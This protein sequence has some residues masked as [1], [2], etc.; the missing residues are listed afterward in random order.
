MRRLVGGLV[1]LA[2]CAALM[3]P[4]AGAAKGTGLTFIFYRVESLWGSVRVDFHG[5]PAAGCERQG[6]CGFSGS[7]VA[8]FINGPPRFGLL[9]RAPLYGTN[10]SF[11]GAGVRVAAT[12]AQTG[13]DS[14]CT[15][16]FTSEYEPLQLA[17]GVRTVGFGVDPDSI[18]PTHCAG[19][20]G[21][22][23]ARLS[24]LH[25]SYAFAALTRPR[26]RLDLARTSRFS[27]AGF[28]GT[29]QSDVH[30]RLRRIPCP[31]GCAVL[32]KLGNLNFTG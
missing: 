15:D 32:G 2:L 6:R 20:R 14:P 8:T 26:A 22:E 23:L 17:G 13:V 10:G 4:S 3:A 5:D 27:A 9:A 19:P 31:G 7:V 18:L 1:G 29:V 16:R 30:L 25:R 12:V 28:S 21:G 24:S 11:A